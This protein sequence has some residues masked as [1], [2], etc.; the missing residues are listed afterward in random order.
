MTTPT[1]TTELERQLRNARL[2]LA[3]TRQSY[4]DLLAAAYASVAA[5]ETGDPEA[6]LQLRDELSCHYFL[7]APPATAQQT[8][9]LAY[10]PALVPAFH[11]TGRSAA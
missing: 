6:L 7:P 9:P 5:A 10:G 4:G 3:L 11:Q 8:A 2:E 1:A